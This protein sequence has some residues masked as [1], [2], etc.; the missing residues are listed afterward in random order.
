[1]LLRL[2]YAMLH[3]AEVTDVAGA[4]TEPRGYNPKRGALRGFLALPEPGAGT[5]HSAVPRSGRHGRLGSFSQV[6]SLLG[7]EVTHGRDGGH[8]AAAVAPHVRGA[9]VAQSGLGAT[10]A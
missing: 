7:Y 4:T 2:L 5:S 8:V 10:R 9:V 6:G 3:T 1:M